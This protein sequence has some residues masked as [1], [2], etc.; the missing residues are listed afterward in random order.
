MNKNA[1]LEWLVKS[2]HNYSAAKVLLDANHYTDTIAVELHYSLEKSLKAILA[3][4]NRKIPKTH[5]LDELYVLVQDNYII[6][7]D[8]ELELIGIATEYHIEESYPS[9]I[10]DLPDRS[11]IKQVLNFTNSFLYR[12]CGK[13]KID[14]NQIIAE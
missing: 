9:V 3:Y 1:A 5:D 11:E 14:I 7:N 10:K 13:L 2:W 12:V 4:E 6:L 8:T